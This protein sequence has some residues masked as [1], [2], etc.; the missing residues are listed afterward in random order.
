MI[1]YN[2]KRMTSGCVYYST[3]IYKNIRQFKPDPTCWKN[4]FPLNIEHTK[5]NTLNNKDSYFWGKIHFIE[6]RFML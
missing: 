2:C 4:Q 6:R 3:V 5:Y 1:V